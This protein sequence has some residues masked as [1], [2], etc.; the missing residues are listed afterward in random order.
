MIDKKYFLWLISICV[1][2]FYMIFKLI[3]DIDNRI[4]FIEYEL[5][6]FVIEKVL[7]VNK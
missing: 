2:I 6:R 5:E 4:N 3:K 7:D 1:V